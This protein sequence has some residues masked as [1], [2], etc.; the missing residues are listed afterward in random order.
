MCFG[1]RLN[2][3]LVMLGNGALARARRIKVRGIIAAPTDA[4]Q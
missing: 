3:P 4:A 2:P 1:I